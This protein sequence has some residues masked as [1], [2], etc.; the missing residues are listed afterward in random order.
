MPPR[1]KRSHRELFIDKLKQLSGGE[2]KLIGNLALRQGLD[3][4]EEKYHRIRIQLRDENL[5]IIGTGR[6]GSVGLADANG[7]SALKIFISYSHTD[8]SRKNELI[9]HIEPLKKLNLIESWHDRKLVAGDDW[10]SSISEELEK[11]DIILL[12]VSID[13]INSK[14]CFDIELDRALELHEEKKAVVIP[15]I[16]RNCLWQHT[17]F[18]KFQAL[19][20]DAK[21]VSAWQDQDEAFTGIAEG[22]RL[23]AEQ[24]RGS[25]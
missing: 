2:Q 10:G 22:I 7:S 6:G 12:L 21:A 14:Y 25:R 16:L 20:R 1:K 15:V 18:A 19:P 4:P 13:F 5:I 23:V 9:K 11:A 17:S 3:W 8:E 24:I